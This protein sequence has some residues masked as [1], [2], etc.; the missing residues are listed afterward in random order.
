MVDY[1]D[2]KR[3]K[4]E[5]GIF[6]HNLQYSLLR[7]GSRQQELEAAEYH[8]YSQETG[9]NKCALLLSTL[10]PLEQWNDAAHSCGVLLT[11]INIT[12]I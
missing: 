8:I 9:S 6:I 11:S 3:L 4:G 5:K 2:K 10:S 12:Y 7:A 1:S